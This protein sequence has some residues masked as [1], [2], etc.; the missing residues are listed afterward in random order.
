MTFDHDDHKAVILLALKNMQISGAA[1]DPELIR[2]IQ[3]VHG[4]IAACEAGTV[5]APEQDA[6]VVNLT[7]R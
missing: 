5:E 1:A 2:H 4:V 6:S 3:L 7:D